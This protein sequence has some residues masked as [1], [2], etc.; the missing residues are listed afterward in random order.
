MGWTMAE[1][2]QS[3]EC[4]PFN[5]SRLF[6]PLRQRPIYWKPPRSAVDGE[7]PLLRAILLICE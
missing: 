6:D 4:G 3:A 7:G 5:G 1:T 2:V